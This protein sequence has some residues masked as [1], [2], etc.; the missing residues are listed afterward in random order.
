MVTQL[1]SAQTVPALTLPTRAE[2]Q[3]WTAEPV[4]TDGRVRR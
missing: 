2:M 1:F 4:G 3:G